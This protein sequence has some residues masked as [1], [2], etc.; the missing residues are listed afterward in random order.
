LLAQ[1]YAVLA[2][3]HANRDAI[4]AD[5]AAEETEADRLEREHDAARMAG[6]ITAL[7]RS[8]ALAKRT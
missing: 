6:G 5:L 2:Y 7:A 8:L 1:V 4:D 3:Y